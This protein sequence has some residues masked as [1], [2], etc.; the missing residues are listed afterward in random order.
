MVKLGLQTKE[1][2]V[3]FYDAQ[4]HIKSMADIAQLLHDKLGK[5][6]DQQRQAALTTMFGTDAIRAANILYEQGAKG[7]DDM[8]TAMSKV[9]A[10]DVAATKL[11]TLNGAFDNF[12]SSLETA[13]I[14]IGTQFLPLLTQIV[15]GATDVMGAFDD[16]KLANLES[17][18]AFAGTAAA[19]AFVGSSLVKLVGTLRLV[20]ASMGPAGWLIVG[21]S[22]LAGVLAQAAVQQNTLDDAMLSS[23][24][25]Q[26]D[27]A[28]SVDAN[29]KAYEELTMKSHLTNEEFARFVDI[30][31]ELAK[32]TD[33]KK[34]ADLTA[35]QDQL[36]QKSGLSND[37]LSHMVD[38][39]KDLTEKVPEATKTI[40]D[41]GNAII[42]NTDA[43]KKYSAAKLDSL[44]KEL[45][46]ERLKTE[47]QYHDLLAKETN[48]VDK[49][50][51]QETNLQSLLSQRTEAQRKSTEEESKLKDMMAN[52]KEYSQA[53]LDTQVQK[54][55]AAK[56]AVETI[57]QQIE[58][59]AG[60]IQQTETDLEKTREKIQ[61]LQGVKDQ[62]A[63]I[64][65]AQ[66]GL[67]SKT[68]EEVSTIDSAIGKLQQQRQEL[69]N[70][71]PA[72]QR[73]TQEYRD[74]KSAIDSQIGSL[75]AT[76]RKLIELTGQASALNEELGRQI[77]KQINEVHYQSV[78]NLVDQG[79]RSAG[80]PQ[81]SYH[82][83]GLVGR[84]QMPTL[85]VGG[86]AS[87]FLDAPN[88]NEVDVRLLKD[89][90]VLTE[91]QQA[92]LMRMLDAGF[93]QKSGQSSGGKTFNYDVKVDAKNV[94]MDEE[95]LVRTLRRMEALYGG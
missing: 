30:N 25:T 69:Q 2:S 94:D 72:A 10:A 55:A 41:Q 31:T 22:L 74:A 59:Q 80:G 46:L 48:L 14:K 11:Q 78:V 75:E 87:Q 21:V 52:T 4:G 89:E 63:Q 36:R 40:T 32:T 33:P 6:T 47:T 85:H 58:K 8:W 20:F 5:L 44:Y 77:N 9:T 12:K 27:N 51:D 79:G 3:A 90:M 70:T 62:M 65:L 26:L 82:T 88:H 50:K 15:R 61:K 91:G 7:I 56:L 93:T 1:G 60:S 64:L 73:N 19:V 38:L 92:N 54:N 42:N 13:G 43:L 71:T 86:L 23:L 17:T 16:V 24:K 29:V 45:D 18:L 76:K 67:N 28:K 35:E 66:S 83:G 84:G 57:Q 68:G 81:S 34:I 49:R 39:N 95:Q 37:E 53:A